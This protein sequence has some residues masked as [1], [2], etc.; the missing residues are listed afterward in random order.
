MGL[1]EQTLAV[2]DFETTGLDT[3]K[4]EIIE[5]AVLLRYP[6][7]NEDFFSWKLHPE[8][9][10]TAEPRALEINGYNPANWANA[11]QAA[12][13]LPKVAALLEGTIWL[14]KNPSFDRGF[15]V[16]S[17]KR[18][19]WPTADKKLP[20]HL[21]DL[22]TLAWEHLAPCGLDRLNLVAIT[23]F[24]RMPHE[25]HTAK[26]DVEVTLAIYDKLLRA[27]WFD[28]FRWRLLHPGRSSRS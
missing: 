20:Y 22:T 28:R 19:G 15:L 9:I 12:D 17:L 3:D 4:H 16:A 5:I 23:K 1:L 7:G 8:H 13:I 26:G 25:S 27:N 11:C 21:I 24:L 18:L 2:V 14:G 6:A 10:E